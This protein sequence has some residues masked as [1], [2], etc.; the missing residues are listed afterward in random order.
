MWAA[1]SVCITGAI[2]QQIL[3]QLQGVIQ[4]TASK[5]I[6]AQI[7]NLIEQYLKGPCYEKLIFFYCLCVY[8]L[9]SYVPTNTQTETEIRQP[10]QFGVG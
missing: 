1:L 10:S 6:A 7:T 5:C 8:I 9:V 4:L 3:V 2:A